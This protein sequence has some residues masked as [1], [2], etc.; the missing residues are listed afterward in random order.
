MSFHHYLPTFTASYDICVAIYSIVMY[1][2]AVQAK[3][4]AL[5]F[6]FKAPSVRN[7]LHYIVRFSWS[8]V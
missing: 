4:K 8:L 5:Q 2:S 1:L 3:I 6:T 7:F